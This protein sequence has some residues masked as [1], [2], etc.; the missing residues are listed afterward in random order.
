M[1]LGVLVMLGGLDCH[2]DG[3]EQVKGALKTGRVGLQ[4]MAG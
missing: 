3:E 2:C 1:G 4:M